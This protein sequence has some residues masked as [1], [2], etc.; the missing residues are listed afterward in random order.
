M[1]SRHY[2]VVV[3]GAGF[4]G[5]YLLKLLRG[6][7]CS[8]RVLEV[9]TGFRYGFIAPKEIDQSIGIQHKHFRAS[10]WWD[11]RHRLYG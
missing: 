2:D 8:V 9:G 6:F 3:V 4:S 10:L 7:G 5:L 11:P 1:P